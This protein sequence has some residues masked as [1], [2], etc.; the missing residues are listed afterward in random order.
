M[1]KWGPLI[2]V[3]LGAFMLLIDT[4]VVLV[5]LPDI[6]NS[7]GS[8]YADLQW[9]MDAYALALAA[10]L[11]GA[12]A[13]A[14]IIGCRKVYLFGVLVFTLASLLCGLAPGIGTLVAARVLQ[15]IGAAAIFATSIALIGSAYQGRDRGIAFGVWGAVSG[16][17]AALG[18]VVGGILTEQVGWRSI[19]LVNIP[20]GVVTLVLASRM[21]RESRG[22]S[23]TRVDLP[24]MAAFT[25]AAGVLTYGLIRAGESGWSDMGVWLA[26]GGAAAA[27]IAFVVIESRVAAPMLDLRLLRNPSFSGILLAGLALQ[28]SAFAYFPQ[29]SVWL[30]SQLGHG[31]VKAGLML[32]PM[33]GTAFVVAALAGRLQLRGVAPRWMIGGGLVLI[34]I[35]ALLLGLTSAGDDWTALVP[36]LAV[37]GVGVGLGTPA[38]SGAVL[39]VVPPQQAGMAGGALNTLRQLGFALGIALTGVVFRSKA[40]SVL[41]DAGI[42]DAHD[43]AEALAGGRGGTIPTLRTGAG[44]EA[45]QHAYVSGLDAVVT[46]AGVVGV[47]AGI[48]VMALVKSGTSTA[49]TPAPSSPDAAP[50]PVRA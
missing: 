9:V 37:S 20:V 22:V 29:V 33:A 34:G 11:L 49:P 31:P 18:P 16:A 30:Q 5:A 43:A 15:G 12:G 45:S 13:L 42:G 1:R 14:D 6:A 48:A 8:S 19:F 41:N 32:S 27:L 38:L 24:G 28:F 35:G 21:L 46:L 40:E 23:G 4:T 10:L 26:L 36:G 17:S 50:D 47:V 44:Q 39:G 25:G 3:S 2:A 7:T